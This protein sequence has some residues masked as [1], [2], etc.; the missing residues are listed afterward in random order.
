M[1]WCEGETRRSDGSP[2][3]LRAERGVG[4]IPKAPQAADTSSTWCSSVT[5]PCW[6]L[7]SVSFSSA[8]ILKPSASP[9]WLPCEGGK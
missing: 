5:R 6:A 3:G 7:V 1:Q 2:E 9:V 8:L 4:A